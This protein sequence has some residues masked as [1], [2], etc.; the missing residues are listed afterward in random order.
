MKN[1][2]NK[3]QAEN[4]FNEIAKFAGYGFNKSH[5]VHMQ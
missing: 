3:G 1:A 4:L 5:A 2:I